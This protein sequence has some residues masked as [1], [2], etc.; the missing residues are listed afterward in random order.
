MRESLWSPQNSHRTG[1][2]PSIRVQ[3]DGSRGPGIYRGLRELS[4]T[5]SLPGVDVS[6]LFP[7]CSKNLE[8][9]CKL[10]T[11]TP[12][13]RG[14]EFAIFVKVF[15][16][17]PLGEH[18]SSPSTVPQKSPKCMYI[19]YWGLV[20]WGE[21][22]R[23]FGQVYNPDLYPP[24]SLQRG[25]LDVSSLVLLLSYCIT[26]SFLFICTLYCSNTLSPR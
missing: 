24:C 16:P 10:P 3:M 6:Q 23:I 12:Q 7:Q 18:H 5:S 9:V 21:D 17:P 25:G 4:L 13:D 14:I 1:Y 19:T 22:F 15:H 2:L 11:A 20:R 26:P 8:I